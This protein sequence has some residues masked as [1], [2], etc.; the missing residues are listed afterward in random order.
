MEQKSNAFLENEKLS[1]LMRKYSLPCIISLVVAALYNIVDQIFIANADY[2]GSY[3]N[4]ANT[5]VFPLTVVA[6]A[7]AVMIGD[8]V[9][10][11]VSISLGADRKEDAHRS[12]GNAILL[13]LGSSLILTALYLLAMEPILTFLGGRVNADTYAC[14][15]EYFFWIALGVP[16]YMFGQAM[17]PIIRSDGSP[18]FAM[19]STVAGAVT[20][21]ILDPVF[22]F[23]LKMGM[24]GAAVATVAGQILTAGLAVWYLFHMKAVKL[25]KRS[26]VLKGRLI[27]R[28]LLLGITSFLSQI[29]LVI[30]MAAVQNMVTRYGALDS[31]F[32]QAEYAQIPL[33]VLGIVMK[34]FQIAI[35]I[36]V[37]L[38]AGCIPVV[39]YNIGAGRK[40]RAKRLFTMLLG[41]E[42][43][44]GL[45]AL[46]IVELMPRQLIAIFG[47][48]NESAYY[49]A[50]AV[51][52]FRI[53]LCMMVPAMVNKG[54]FIYLQALGK[55][56]P[57]MLLSMVREIIFGVFLPILLPRF[58]GLDGVLYSFPTA[59][60]LTFL[61]TLVVILKVYRELSTENGFDPLMAPAK[62]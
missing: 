20:N 8:G 10:A 5:V 43:A 15:K 52:C 56:G 22:I 53:Y 11:F 7:I 60:I 17:N 50:F 49:T 57:S 27:R 35:S 19:V 54:T 45:I 58:F 32:G 23:P 16:F 28:F 31:V 37:G 2:L 3:G 44:V 34:F 26:F 21:I 18:R 33:A 1:V 40:D 41:W 4:A 51:R 55:A 29:S 39:G 38:A 9:C 59:D 48:G 13:C 12:I 61:L 6:L 25:E 36:S 47:A 30:S 24:M 62:A 42:A 46:L 14:A